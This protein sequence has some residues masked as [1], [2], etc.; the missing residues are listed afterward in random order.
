MELSRV[1]VDTSAY[2]G[3]MRGNAGVVTAV[4]SAERLYLNTVVLGELRAGFAAGAHRDK[5]EAELRTFLQSPRVEVVALDAETSVFYAAI[6]GS[7]R[8]AGTPI[9]ANDLWIAATAMQHGLCLLT[10]DAHFGR[11]QQIIVQHIE[12]K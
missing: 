3:F 2:S 12:S 10:M 8:A 6:Y 9:P 1:L 7:L 4:R 5:N 11:V